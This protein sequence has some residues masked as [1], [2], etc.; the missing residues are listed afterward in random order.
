MKLGVGAK[1][2]RI[3]EWPIERHLLKNEAENYS[4]IVM[5]MGHLFYMFM[6]K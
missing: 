5:Y 6:L 3:N 4:C 1:V 2:E